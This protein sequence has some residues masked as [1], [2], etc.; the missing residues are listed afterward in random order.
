MEPQDYPISHFDGMSRLGHALKA[1]PAQILDHRYSYELFGSW[2]V[3]IRYKGKVAQ[4]S[5]DG[6]ENYLGV[7]RSP[8]RKHPYTYGPEEPVTAFAGC[9]GELNDAA[10]QQICRELTK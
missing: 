6:K 9:L 10:I 4:F 5:Y 7:R 3:V 2:C 8:D 1:L